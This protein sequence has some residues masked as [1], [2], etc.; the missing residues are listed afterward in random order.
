MN[1]WISNTKWLIIP[2]A[3]IFALIALAV[4]YSLGSY[5]VGEHGHDHATIQDHDHQHTDPSIAATFVDYNRATHRHTHRHWGLANKW[6]GHH[7]F[8]H[9]R[10]DI[11]RIFKRHHHIHLHPGSI[12]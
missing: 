4:A 8:S 10:T 2:G 1:N 7:V 3:V 12:Y 11:I 9:K 6:R 5:S